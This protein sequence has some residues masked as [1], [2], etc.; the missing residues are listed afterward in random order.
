MTPALKAAAQAVNIR[1]ARKPE[2]VPACKNCKHFTYD[3]SERMGMRGDYIEKMGKRCT[4]LAINVT[5][6]LVCDLHEFR[7]VDHRDV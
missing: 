7:H 6:N 3:A 1:K 4:S 5:S 2:I